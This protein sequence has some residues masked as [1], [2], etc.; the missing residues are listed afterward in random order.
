MSQYL[1][2]SPLKE[3]KDGSL[4]RFVAC[5]W[6]VSWTDISLG[7]SFDL[8]TPR[9]EIHVPFGFFRIGFIRTWFNDRRF[10]FIRFPDNAPE[11]GGSK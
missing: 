1:Y 9:V 6:F 10:G 7:I 4:I 2:L 11:Q 5:F 3:T 8:R